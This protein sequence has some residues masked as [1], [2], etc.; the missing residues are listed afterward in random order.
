MIAIAFVSMGIIALK[1]EFNNFG[2]NLQQIQG[3][4][5]AQLTKVGVLA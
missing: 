5:L 1:T 3:S 2:R 4:G